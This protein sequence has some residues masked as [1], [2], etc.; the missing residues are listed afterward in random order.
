MRPFG[1]GS[2]RRSLLGL[3]LCEASEGVYACWTAVSSS[4]ALHNHA[5]RIMS[6]TQKNVECQPSQGA[7]RVELLGDGYEARL[8]AIESRHDADEVE[9]GPAEPVHLIDN[10]AVHAA[11][12][13]VGEE[14]RE[15]RPFHA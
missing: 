12:G 11:S 10:H 13:D 1:L 8:V 3:Q 9:Q 6:E 2:Q 14:A 5:L 4:P 7:G 15:R